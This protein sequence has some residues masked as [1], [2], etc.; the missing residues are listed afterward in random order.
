LRAAEDAKTS[1]R[2]GPLTILEMMEAPVEDA[3]VAAVVAVKSVQEF[4]SINNN[5]RGE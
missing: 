5:L 3:V 4:A 1:V 2:W